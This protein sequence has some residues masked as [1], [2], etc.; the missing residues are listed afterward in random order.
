MNRR[1]RHG[2]VSQPGLDAKAL[3]DLED[4]DIGHRCFAGEQPFR[5]LAIEQS[6]ADEFAIEQ[7]GARRVPVVVQEQGQVHAQAALGPAQADRGRQV[8]AEGLSCQG[9]ALAAAHELGDRRGETQ[10]DQGLR[11]QRVDDFRRGFAEQGS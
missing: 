2:G 6:M 8:V 5:S 3:E 7:Q 10:L 9:A 4:R 1:T 11:E